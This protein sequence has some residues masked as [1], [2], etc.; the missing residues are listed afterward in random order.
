MAQL[1]SAGAPLLPR[2]SS[3][4]RPRSRSLPGASPSLSAWD[5]LPSRPGPRPWPRSRSPHRLRAGPGPAPL[6]AGPGPAPPAGAAASGPV[7]GHARARCQAAAR[8]NGDGGGGGSPRP[9]GL[10]P[11]RGERQRS[12]SP[13]RLHWRRHCQL[14]QSNTKPRYYLLFLRKTRPN[15]R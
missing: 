6:T 12:W 15:N 2:G 4:A 3:R 5:P 8:G 11:G 13:L 14:K 1:R 10:W 7:T 9:G